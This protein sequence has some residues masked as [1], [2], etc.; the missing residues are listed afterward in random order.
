MDG[1]LR[2]LRGERGEKKQFSVVDGDLFAIEKQ[3][4]LFRVH[5]PNRARSAS[6]TM[7]TR[8]RVFVSAGLAAA[9]APGV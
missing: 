3:T 8:V 5:T 9:A 4:F 6:S 1:R 7:R 2:E